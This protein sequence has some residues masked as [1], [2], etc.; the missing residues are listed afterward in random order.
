MTEKKQMFEFGGKTI[1]D[2]K[3]AIEA[4]LSTSGKRGNDDLAEY[5]RQSDPSAVEDAVKELKC[6]SKLIEELKS[7]DVAAKTLALSILEILALVKAP[8]VLG[9]ICSAI[10]AVIS[11]MEGPTEL[12]LGAVRCCEALS[13][14][15]NITEFLVAKGVIDPLKRLLAV[16]SEPCVYHSLLVI[17]NVAMDSAKSRRRM[18]EEKVVRSLTHTLLC[19]YYSA[20]TK[21]QVVRA[22]FNIGK[23]S[24]AKE[25]ATLFPS[26]V[27]QMAM[28]SDPLVQNEGVWCLHLMSGT[29]VPHVV[30]LECTS[31]TLP[32]L[33]MQRKQSSSKI[34]PS[35][36]DCLL[37]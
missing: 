31:H 34:S 5:L 20:E 7:D 11:A 16:G 28:C 6:M 19:Q 14:H 24:E 8:T 3:T 29:T 26:I 12:A 18:C 1:G 35:F 17:G 32:C 30:C 13:T 37:H 27:T 22:C 4:L 10:E 21:D 15:D 9:G 25:P 23:I 36:R 33:N 2:A